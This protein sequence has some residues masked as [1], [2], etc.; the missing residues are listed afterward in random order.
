MGLVGQCGPL[1]GTRIYPA[2]DSPYY[3]VGMWICAVFMVFNVV[4]ALTLRTV[5]KWE[6]RRLDA[7]YR[8]IDQRAGRVGVEDDGPNFRYVLWFK[9]Y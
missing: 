4:L 5:L 3:R 7:K 1:L 6:N 2:T 8:K 9:D